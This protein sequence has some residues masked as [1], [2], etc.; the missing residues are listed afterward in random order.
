MA[1]ISDRL[2]ADCSRCAGLCCVVPAFTASADFAIDKPA[3]QPCPN[4]RDDSGCGIHDRLRPLGFPGCVAYDCFGAG[5]QVVQ[6]TFGGAGWRDSP[7][8]ARSMFAVFPVMRIL[9]ELLWYLDEGRR[10]IP[11]ESRLRTDLVET[12]AETERLTGGDPDELGALD[13]DEH[14]R[15]VAGLLARVGVVVR[16]DIADPPRLRGAQLIGYDLRGADLQGAD[17]RGAV[18]VGADLRDAN[19]RRAEL[20]GADLRGTKLAGADL[21][22]SLYLVQ[23]QL[24]TATG[25]ATTRLSDPLRHPGH[26]H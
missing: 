17:L 13:V 15:N 12:F 18:L 19:L 9:H 23:S 2:R 26:W 6:T 1:G 22:D 20:I 14:R 7:D 25:D 5:Q 4:L 16:A 8:V 3:R 21:R 24:E 11:V 10:R